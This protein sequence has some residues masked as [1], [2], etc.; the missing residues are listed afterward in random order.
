MV[1]KPLNI[2]PALIL[3]FPFQDQ[4]W[5]KKFLIA[6]LLVFFSFIPVIPVVLLLGYSAEIIRLIV[7]ENESP[8]LPEWDDLSNYFNGGI[9][10]F[11]I[12]AIYMIPATLLI[13]IGYFSM[14]LPVIFFGRP[15]F[16]ALPLRDPLVFRRH[17]AGRFCLR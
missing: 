9:R 17:S 7:I 2:D 15:P 6:S 11:G 10:L 8:S 13:G 1:K 3:A 12:S 14:F 5:V 4:N 16:P